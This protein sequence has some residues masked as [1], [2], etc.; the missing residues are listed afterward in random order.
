M[1]PS[2]IPLIEQ[3]LAHSIPARHGLCAHYAHTVQQILLGHNIP[4]C[5]QAGNLQWPVVLPENDDGISNTHY[6]Y[7]WDPTS[8]QSR[9]AVARG[10]LPEI[11][12]WLGNPKTQEIIDFSTRHLKQAAQAHGVTWNTPDPPP[13][14]WC[15]GEN[16]PPGVRYTPIREATIYAHHILSRL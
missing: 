15:Q 11:H 1:T 6:A 8:P 5:I 9:W 3:T 16:L 10:H 2:L 13:Y 12:I 7:M 4:T 14:I